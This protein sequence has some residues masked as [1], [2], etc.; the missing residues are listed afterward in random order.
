[1]IHSLP[2]QVSDRGRLK[3]ELKKSES[4]WGVVSCRAAD[5]TEQQFSAWYSELIR[6]NSCL[7]GPKGSR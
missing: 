5:G 1:M 4:R 2:L 6:L 7:Q 3:G